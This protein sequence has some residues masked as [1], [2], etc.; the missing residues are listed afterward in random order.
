MSSV[1][2][3]LRWYLTYLKMAVGT[4][5]FGAM[6]FFLYAAIRT[7]HIPPSM[8]AAVLASLATLVAAMVFFFSLHYFT[9]QKKKA[10]WRYLAKLTGMDAQGADR[11]AIKTD[12][13]TVEQAGSSG[14]D[15]ETLYRKVVE[16]DRTFNTATVP[17]KEAAFLDENRQAAGE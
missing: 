17:I 7:N 3:I 8:V 10:Y 9:G 4:M 12:K 2:N 6:F 14:E 5:A 11:G 16:I 1:R 13:R 15:S